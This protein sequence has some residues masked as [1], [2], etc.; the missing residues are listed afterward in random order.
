MTDFRALDQVLSG[1]PIPTP[2]S[3]IWY[4]ISEQTDLHGVRLSIYDFGPL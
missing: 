4:R 2:H 3:D 1:A